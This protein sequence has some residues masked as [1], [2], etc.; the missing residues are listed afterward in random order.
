M[1]TSADGLRAEILFSVLALG[2]CQG[3]VPA[4]EDLEFVDL[5]SGSTAGLRGL[6]VV[7]G[8]VIWVSGSA[9]T[10]LLWSDGGASFVRRPVAGAEEFDFRD[11]HAIDERTAWLMSAGTG[12]AS[13]IWLTDDGGESWRLQ[14]SN[15]HP[16]GFL[17]GM[18]FWDAK[19]GLVMGDPVGGRFFVAL[20]DDGGESWE[21]IE[22]AAM[23]AALPGEASF[24]ASGTGIV[25][26]GRDHAWFCTGAGGRARVF[27]SSDGGR[28]WKVSDT[29]IPA[30]VSSAGAFSLAFRDTRHGVLVGG[31]YTLPDERAGNCAITTDGG[32]SWTAIVRGGPSGY[33]SAVTSRPGSMEFVAVGRGGGDLSVDGGGTWAPVGAL[34]E[35]WYCAAFAGRDTLFVSGPDGRIGRWAP[36]N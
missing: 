29:P 10:C 27:R 28:N 16:E 8:R 21:E 13:R 4:L 17:D 1:H 33:R 32:A 6:C 12:A 23:P 20:T 19:R 22:N 9:G 2:A 14:Y 31:D 11:V 3:S 25:T 5:A 36:A 26:A 30:G 18:A 24:A 15:P 7:D 34:G 35:G